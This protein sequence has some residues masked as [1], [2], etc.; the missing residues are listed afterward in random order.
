MDITV[1]SRKVKVPPE[2]RS[3]AEEK[4]ARVQRF[5]HDVQR[6]EVD[7]SEARNP[8]IG[9][10]ERCEVTVHLKRQVLKAHAAAPDMQTALDR[11]IEKLEHQAQKLKEKRVSLRRRHVHGLP[12]EPTAP[13]AAQLPEDELIAP[14]IA[15]TK[16]FQVKPMDVPE[17]ALQMD[18]L[19]HDFYLFVNAENDRA[20]VVYRRDDG[21]FGL[22]EASG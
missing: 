19:G 20:S 14:A 7:F 3:L 21:T 11:T 2:L 16:R 13:D 6:I 12:P 1:R 8:R 18:L 9:N 17:A 22:I 15:K 5:T 4:L 10:K